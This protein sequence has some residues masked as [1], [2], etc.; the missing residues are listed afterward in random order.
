MATLSTY[1]ILPAGAVQIVTPEPLSGDGGQALNDNFKHI[2]DSVLVPGGSIGE[3]QYN[4]GGALVGAGW[5]LEGAVGAERLLSPGTADDGSTAL[6]VAGSAAFSGTVVVGED[7]HL[8]GG[9]FGSESVSGGAY[10]CDLR[11][12]NPT[13]NKAQMVLGGGTPGG[14][15]ARAWSFGTDPYASGDYSFFL[16]S[17]HLNSV[18]MFLDDDGNLTASANVSVGGALNV[19]G[20]AVIDGSLQAASFN[21]AAVP[22][23]TGSRSSGAALQNLLAALAGLGLIIDSSTP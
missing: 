21:P 6:Q 2:A 22:T 23:I 4:D 13:C 14:S 7:F 11:N 19:T 8:Y 15:Q 9:I 20:T 1:K 5:K 12:S 18:I 10:G 17:G 3:I 16:Y